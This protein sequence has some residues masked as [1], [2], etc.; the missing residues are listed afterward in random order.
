MKFS[1]EKN[2]NITIR[3]LLKLREA[4]GWT[5]ASI[6]RIETALANSY[7][8]YAIRKD[9]QLIGFL[10]VITDKGIHAFIVDLNVHPAF[11]KHG[12]GNALVQETV[13]DLKKEGYYHIQ[14]VFYPELEEF[15]RK[16]G[17]EII[18]AGMITNYQD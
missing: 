15:Y 11:Q 8:T 7:Q 3:E 14:L 10:R 12:I 18:Q 16:C 5:R 2:N 9:N 6:E 1:I 4:V 13:N 17:F